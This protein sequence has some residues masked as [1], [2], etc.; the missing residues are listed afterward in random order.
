[1]KRK[2]KGAFTLYFG[3]VFMSVL[4]IAL[5][6]LDFARMEV[7]KAQA[8]RAMELTSNSLITPYDKAFQENYGFFMS[9][10]GKLKEKVQFMLE[11]N[12]QNGK[13]D[14]S[15]SKIKPIAM[16]PAEVKEQ[17]LEYMKFRG[18]LVAVSKLYSMFSSMESILSNSDN[19]DERM[20]TEISNADFLEA[21]NNYR[22]FVQG[23][24]FH[25]ERPE[26]KYIRDDSSEA[27][28]LEKKTVY[29]EQPNGLFKSYDIA[30]PNL[31]RTNSY[32]IRS[33]TDFVNDNPYAPYMNM[34]DTNLFRNAWDDFD[35]E[36][37]SYAIDHNGTPD[38][39][40]NLTLHIGYLGSDEAYEHDQI[41]TMLWK[42]LIDRKENGE[43]GLEK[44]IELLDELRYDRFEYEE[45]DK[46]T[47]QDYEDLD[48]FRLYTNMGYYMTRYMDYY[49]NRRE[50][51]LEWDFVVID[52]DGMKDLGAFNLALN[53]DAYYYN[54]I[55]DLTE[56]N[57]RILTGLKAANKKAK[58]KLKKVAENLEAYKQQVRKEM[59]QVAGS[60]AKDPNYV[61][62]VQPKL[63]DKLEM[64]QL[65]EERL[66]KVQSENKFDENIDL[67]DQMIKKLIVPIVAPYE[68]FWD[69]FDLKSLRYYELPVAHFSD[70]ERRSI[71][72]QQ[73]NALKL[74]RELSQDEM[75][76]E[77]SFAEIQARSI[78]LAEV[79]GASFDWYDPDAPLEKPKF[80]KEGFLKL[81]AQYD[82]NCRNMHIDFN[83]EQLFVQTLDSGSGEKPE[84]IAEKGSGSLK[85]F[86]KAAGKVFDTLFSFGSGKEISE[87]EFKKLPSYIYFYGG[88]DPGYDEGVFEADTGGTDNTKDTGKSSQSWFGAIKNMVKSFKNLAKDPL[89]TIYVN[90]YIM[91]AFHSSVT[92]VGE[93]ESQIN[94]KFQ[95]K[96]K[97]PEKKDLPLEAEIE[98]VINGDR[99]DPSN[100][101]SMS[102][103]IIM[104][105]V[106]PNLLFVL[107]N[108]ETNALASALA[109]A[110]SA[111]FPPIYPLV[112]LV[113]VVLWAIAESVV[114]V[115]VL[116][117]GQRVAFMKTP[118]EF[119]LSPSGF[120]ELAKV[121]AKA[122]V[123][124]VAEAAKSG[125]SEGLEQMDRYVTELSQRAKDYIKRQADKLANKLGADEVESSMIYEFV[126]EK[127]QM[128]EQAVNDYEKS[129]DIY[130]ETVVGKYIVKVE[131]DKAKGILT[132]ET[133][134]QELIEESGSQ[135]S[136]SLMKAVEEN[137]D[138]VIP[139]IN[140]KL[141]Q[142]LNPNISGSQDILNK[143]KSDPSIR[144]GIDKGKDALREKL[145]QKL[146]EV[147]FGPLENE[148]AEQKDRIKSE[149]QNYLNSQVDLGAEQLQEFIGDSIKDV[150]SDT[151]EISKTE[152]STSFFKLGYEDYLRI[153]LLFTPEDAKLM[154][155]LDLIQLREK[156]QI[157]KYMAGVEMDLGFKIKYLFLPRMIQI[158]KKQSDAIDLRE[159]DYE[160]VDFRLRSVAGY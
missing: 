41:M 96:T 151:P 3:V 119:M 39:I 137:A 88:E 68:E 10:N 125:I 62:S 1:M 126:N 48:I 129:I 134:I 29:S 74:T 4:L 109:S 82:E 24:T 57:F 64:I 108:S 117:S 138:Q 49:F 104:L 65:M 160:W 7:Y 120:P 103:D 83:K 76:P 132:G 28:R 67:L 69:N 78:A 31:N 81:K 100:N 37:Y 46:K 121:L 148:F 142:E 136:K 140:Q 38:A 27:M 40:A 23:W 22:Y 73:E 15:R 61:A 12:F 44:Q 58:E 54:S 53:M 156:K 101:K 89:G 26:Y 55:M 91:T 87:E 66:Q 77:K 147:V 110:I 135:I 133:D 33:F 93:Y 80:D 94:L 30:F 115:F 42:E 123:N 143:L 153:D 154:R 130:V 71:P 16:G 21:L 84:T 99:S 118:S 98:Y 106:I 52:T 11:E 139:L 36:R 144:V 17:I 50:E 25:E 92:G 124:H 116:R 85:D 97:Y 90:E 150:F 155:V 6:V 34:G 112:Y 75:M 8:Q 2:R 60:D 9:P 105:R 19:F 95:D 145:E 131:K 86:M 32:F 5:S 102:N 14:Y 149:L 113:I 159:S 59:T 127:Y 141:K 122:A 114:D 70:Q 128:V 43:E 35:I 157:S 56:K 146:E 107:M 111:I 152:Q 45:M 72:L 79:T 18:P 51:E 20:E 13:A 63:E 47:V 158:A